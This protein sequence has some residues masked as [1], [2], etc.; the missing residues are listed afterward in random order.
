ME[1]GKYFVQRSRHGRTY[2][3]LEQGVA[4]C[5]VVLQRENEHQSLVLESSSLGD[6]SSE[7][8]LKN[9]PA[10]NA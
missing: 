9:T 8:C 2:S 6:A 4:G 7:T 10:R 1:G 5:L 3:R